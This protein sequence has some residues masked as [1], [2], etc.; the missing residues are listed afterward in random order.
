MLAVMK[1]FP[2]LTLLIVLAI[3]GYIVIGIFS[4]VSGTEILSPTAMWTIVFGSFVL[5][6]AI[7]IVAVIAGIGGGVLFTPLVMAFTSIDTL[8]VRATGLVVAMFSGL[9]SSGPF[10][11]KG[12]SDIKLVFYCS[13]PIVVGAMGGSF[14]AI[15][16]AQYLG[17]AGD[18]LVRLSLGVLLIF[19]AVIFIIG[20]T[21]TEYPEPKKIDRLS[22][23]LDLRGGYWEESLNRPV[24]YQSTRP[25]LGGILFL[26]VGFTGGFF[27]LGGGWAV[28]PVLNLVM[29]TPLKVSAAC[30]G[31]LLALGNSCAIWPYITYGALIAVFAAPWMLGQVVG[32]IMGAH[33]LARIK[34]GIVRKILI[35]LLFLTSIK[36]VSRGVETL[37]G[38]NIPIF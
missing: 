16:L 5:S 33:I 8:I 23:K 30:S 9:I 12:L 32:G 11:K 36:L 27:G 1:R 18:A 31:V 6:T 14:A 37:F 26:L 22:N 24:Y 2:E 38:I 10:M 17:A 15:A 4:Q 29:S 25:L 20:G 19:I 7:A 21:K 35:V 28:V 34:A 3:C 13:V